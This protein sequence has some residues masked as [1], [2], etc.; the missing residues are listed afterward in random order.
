MDTIFPDWLILIKHWVSGGGTGYSLPFLVGARAKNRK[1]ESVTE[2]D[3]RVL[4]DEIFN[5]PVKNF[6]IQVII[7]PNLGVPVFGILK[8]QIPG[9][10]FKSTI[11][12]LPSVYV[13]QD[14]IT[15]WGNSTD[16]VINGMV[17]DSKQPIEH[18]LFSRTFMQT[19]APF[20]EEEIGRINR[21]L[22]NL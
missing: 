8:E 5:Y 16:D 20:S 19:W 12:N 3:A 2:N 7:C 22:S 14:L 11:K 4:L 1:L 10:L 9:K 6:I 15:K 17:S 18:N 21:L 13:R